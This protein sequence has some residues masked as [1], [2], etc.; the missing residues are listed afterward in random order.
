MSDVQQQ[1]PEP[2]QPSPGAVMWKV[3]LTASGEVRDADGNLVNQEE[4]E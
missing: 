1:Q 3:E 2:E 4:Q